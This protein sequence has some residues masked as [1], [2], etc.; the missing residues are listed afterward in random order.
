M[1]KQIIISLLLIVISV[2]GQNKIFFKY[3]DNI[4]LEK[5]SAQKEAEQLLRN[6]LGNDVKSLKIKRLTTLH[7]NNNIR[8]ARIYS[9]EYTDASL[10]SVIL[11]SLQNDPNIEYV[12]IS[13]IY[14]IDSVV[15]DDSLIGE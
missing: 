10:T 5:I 8:I 9:L 1:I 2:S 15:P 3:N 6:Y 13:N 12:Q 11:T 14:K 4:A 7:L